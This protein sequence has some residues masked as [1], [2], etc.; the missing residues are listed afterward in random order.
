M[1]RSD[2]NSQHIVYS[3]GLA[4]FQFDSVAVELGDALGVKG[5]DCTDQ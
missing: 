1:L 4:A 2:L 3:A 5:E